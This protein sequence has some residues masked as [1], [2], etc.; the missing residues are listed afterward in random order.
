[1][2]YKRLQ[3]LGKEQ[4][5]KLILEKDKLLKDFEDEFL[6]MEKLGGRLFLDGKEYW[7]WRERIK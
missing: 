7:I 4:L 1:M 3:Q 2:N 6:K 5:I